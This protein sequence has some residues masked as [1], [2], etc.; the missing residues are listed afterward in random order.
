MAFR[1]QAPTDFRMNR[2]S[3]LSTAAGDGRHDQAS[4]PCAR[5]AWARKAPQGGVWAMRWCGGPASLTQKARQHSTNHTHS[6]ATYEYTF[7]KEIN[8]SRG[9]KSDGHS[10]IITRVYNGVN[11]IWQVGTKLQ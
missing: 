11:S 1:L 10:I 7:L 3:A 6:Y 2:L 8:T 4:L 9:L 5:D